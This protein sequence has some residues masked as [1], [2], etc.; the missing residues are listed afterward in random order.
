MSSD[1][2]VMKV[3]YSRRR[4][5][6]PP[7]ILICG[8]I[9]GLVVVAA[10]L[11]QRVAPHDPAAQDLVHGLA[12][13]SREHWL[14]TDNLGRD[15]FSRVVAGTLSAIS[16]PAV[17]ALGGMV[18]GGAL[19]MIAGYLGGFLGGGILRSADLLQALPGLLVAIVVLGILGGGYW[20]AVGVLIFLSIPIDVR[21]VRAATLEQRHRTYVEAARAMGLPSWK[22]V[23][24]HIWPNV[25]PIVVANTF[26][27]FAAAIVALASLS[28]LG[29][30]VPPGATNWGKMLAENRSLITT[31]PIIALAPAV[32]L[33]LTAVSANIVGDW[34][35][36]RLSDEGQ[37]V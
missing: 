35:Y 13:P 37:H 3:G 7:T 33:I 30:G 6:A 20:T 10:V 31:R 5:V 32:A 23:L 22:I 18:I 29:L 12:G 16:G 11:G 25:L 14:G 21:V 27:V 19:G 28:F 17:V 2:G 1:V 4:A 8:A 15:V 34:L 26:V 36:E 9:L 24:R